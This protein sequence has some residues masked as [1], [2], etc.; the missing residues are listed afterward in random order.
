MQGSVGTFSVFSHSCCNHCNC[1]C[2]NVRIAGLY[3]NFKGGD[4]I[5]AS[6]PGILDAVPERDPSKPEL[7]Q[8]YDDIDAHL[9]MASAYTE[10][11]EGPENTK[12]T[13]TIYESE[14]QGLQRRWDSPD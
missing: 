5:L 1:I 3:G 9:D 11:P 12:D 10:N 14:R 13:M 6:R 2:E 8:S 4:R 7:L